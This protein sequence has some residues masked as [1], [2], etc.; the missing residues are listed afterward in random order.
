M[1]LLPIMISNGLGGGT[2]LRFAES[3]RSMALC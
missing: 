3:G 2:K 1:S